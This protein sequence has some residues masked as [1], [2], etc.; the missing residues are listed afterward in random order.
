[1]CYV[2]HWHV[3][4]V[5]CLCYIDSSYWFSSLTNVLWLLFCVLVASKWD[6]RC[7]CGWQGYKLLKQ[8][9]C[10]RGT[11]CKARRSSQ[12][13]CLQQVSHSPQGF[14]LPLHS[15][16]LLLHRITFKCSC[17]ASFAIKT[18]TFSC[19][20]PD[21]GWRHVFTTSVL[22]AKPKILYNPCNASSLLCSW[23]CFGLWCA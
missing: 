6:G 19:H 10:A 14:K 1:M 17:C 12:V 8:K 9:R 4:D 22:F 20:G 5:R 2:T 13:G 18:S 7:V 15:H 16:F 21:Y 3:F 23:Q 11:S